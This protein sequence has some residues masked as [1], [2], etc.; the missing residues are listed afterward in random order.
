M[1]MN[2]KINT[3]DCVQDPKLVENSDTLVNFVFMFDNINVGSFLEAIFVKI[4]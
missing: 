1:I 4:F 2:E 3:K